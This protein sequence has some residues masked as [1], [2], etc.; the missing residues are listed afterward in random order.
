MR[1]QELCLRLQRNNILPPSSI[2]NL[3]TS[4]LLLL[5]AELRNRIYHDL[6][7]AHEIFHLTQKEISPP[8]LRTCK[9]LRH[10]VSGLFYSNT[11]LQFNDPKVLLRA[12][13]SLDPE[14]ISLIPEL[15]YDTSE[16][17]TEA[18]SWSSAFRELPGLDEDTKLQALRDALEKEDVVLRAGVL[19]ARIRIGCRDVWTS[20]P[21]GEALEAVKRGSIV[22]R[23]MF[24]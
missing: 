20:D 1:Q 13:G 11:I 24:V 7:P 15:R 16:I 3:Q 23:M 6:F 2:L 5:P 21:L 14:L 22:G 8:I 9:K 12:L 18:T 4:R 19:K 10:E 17:C